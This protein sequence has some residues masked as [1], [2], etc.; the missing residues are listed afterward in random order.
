MEEETQGWEEIN[1]GAKGIDVAT[2]MTK[3]RVKFL[4]L[5]QVM[6][7]ITRWSL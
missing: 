7:G 1:K 2:K 3:D 5:F 4:H 6:R